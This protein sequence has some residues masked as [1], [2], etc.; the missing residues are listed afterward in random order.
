MTD[1]LRS[2]IESALH[3]RVKDLHPLSGG[4]A[5]SACRVRMENQDHVIGATPQKNQPWV[6]AESGAW[7]RFWWTHRLEPM[8][9][10]RNTPELTRKGLALS[11]RLPDLLGDPE[12]PPALLH[13]DLW[14]GNVTADAAGQPVMFDPAPYY[15]CR[16]AGR[17]DRISIPSTMS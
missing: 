13:G 15:G 9:R 7:A 12:D 2:D 14:S 1:T 6:P 8:L 3:L 17:I 16:E 5:A 4:D 10:K 11:D